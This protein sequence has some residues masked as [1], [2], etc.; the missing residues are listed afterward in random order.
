MDY[1]I[2]TTVFIWL[3]F[4]LIT[5]VGM[6]FGIYADQFVQEMKSTLQTS[7]CLITFCHACCC[8]N[9]RSHHCDNNRSHLVKMSIFLLMVRVARCHLELFMPQQKG[10]AS[11]WEHF[12]SCMHCVPSFSVKFKCHRHS[13]QFR[14]TRQQEPLQRMV[15]SGYFIQC[16][17]YTG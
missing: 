3:V 13:V 12:L 11:W 7:A 17:N 14:H 10:A 1:W 9:I 16:V 15:F 2:I 8:C 5:W 4:M 6:L